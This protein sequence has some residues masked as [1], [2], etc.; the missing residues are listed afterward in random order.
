MSPAS[1]P[2]HHLKKIN[3]RTLFVL[4]LLFAF[5]A[6]MSYAQDLT[7]SQLQS[8]MTGLSAAKAQQYV[9]PLNE[10]M[11]SAGINTPNRQAAFL[12]QLGHESGNLKWFKE[13]ASGKYVF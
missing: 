4:A 8:I 10:A 12:A 13:F 5:A 3:M 9:G 2:K 7:A 11:K 1:Q 6:T